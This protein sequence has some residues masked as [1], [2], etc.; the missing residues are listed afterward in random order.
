[1]HDYDSGLDLD[2]FQVTAD[3]AVDGVPAGRNLAARFK[4]K[5]QGVWE[6]TLTKPLTTLPR[7][8]LTVSVKD[9]RVIS[10]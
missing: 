6:L 9:K 3:F 4:A 10:R 5:S 8:T 1:M 7:G 2:S